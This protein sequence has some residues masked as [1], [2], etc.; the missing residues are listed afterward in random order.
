MFSETH[1][2]ETVSDPDW[3][4][5]ASTLMWSYTGWDALG[6]MAGEVQ[7]P[8]KTYIRGSLICIIMVTI[9][10]VLP[11]LTCVQVHPDVAT[12]TDSSF[13]QFLG[14]D[15]GRGLGWLATAAC[16]ASSV[17]LFQ[18]SLSASALAMWALAGGDASSIMPVRHIPAVF[19]L[20]YKR[21]CPCTVVWRGPV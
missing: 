10:Y 3:S 1:Y 19:G 11:V 8:A 5:F 20:T 18:S 7:N 6:C 17:G 4:L 13:L 2:V 12:W 14:A 9:T 21:A 16:I 15:V